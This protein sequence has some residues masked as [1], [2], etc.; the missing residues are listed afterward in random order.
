M[1]IY[2]Y[3]GKKNICGSRIKQARALRNISQSELAAKMQVEGITIERDSISRIEIGTRFVT[4]YE[5]KIFAKVL[6]VNIMWLL[7]D[8]ETP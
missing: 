3:G 1:K 7:S 2:D 6:K 4:D 5:L 8:E